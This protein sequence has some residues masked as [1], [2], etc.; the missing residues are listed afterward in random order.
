[1][2]ILVTAFDPFGGE[3]INPAR[4]AAAALPEQIGGARIVTLWIPTVF[5]KGAAM[6]TAAMDQLRPDAVVSLGQA[7]G[8]KAVTPERIAIN[9]MDARIPD[10]E[11]QQP[12]EQIIEPGGPDGCFST[13]PVAAMAEAIRK[14]DLP[15]EVSNTAG[16]F[17][18]NQVMYCTLRHAAKAMPDTTCGFIHVPY[19][20][21]QAEGK[22]GTPS[23]S[24]AEIVKAL[25]AALAV[26]AAQ[27]PVSGENLSAPACI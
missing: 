15:G 26:V 25:T 10:N 5:E 27:L 12:L 11:G 23:L 3:S 19:L 1:M 24:L 4:E 7:G 14:A 16:T 9:L 13:L 17:V 22:P 8:R 21:E 2:T 18:C 20:P 6:V